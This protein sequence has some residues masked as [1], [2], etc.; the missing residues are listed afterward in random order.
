MERSL[1]VDDFL[2]TF[3]SEQQCKVRR[4]K[5][6]VLEVTLTEELDQAIM[7]RP[8]YWQYIKAMKQEGVPMTLRFYTDLDS[9]QTDAEW[10]HFATPRMNDICDQLER[11]GRYLQAFQQL[12]VKQQTALHPWLILNIQVT[13]QGKQVREEIHSLG[14]NLIN[15]QIVTEMMENLAPLAFHQVISPHCFIISP[16]IKIPSAYKRLENFLMARIKRQDESW[17]LESLRSLKD[18]LLLMSHF[19]Y[20]CQHRQ[21]M[22]K[23]IIL[24]YERYYPQITWEVMNGGILYLEP[25]ALKKRI[26]SR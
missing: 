23:E 9:N 18:E 17:A 19:D 2:Y 11:S 10:I 3:F 6:K 21:E 12:D 13:F 20:D 8:F 16:L 1:C 4:R 24:A 5:D 7:N 22:L 15:G 14:L 26:K 25:E